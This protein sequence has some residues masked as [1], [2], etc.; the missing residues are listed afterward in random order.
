MLTDLTELTFS[1]AC[2]P[3]FE[4]EKTTDELKTCFTDLRVLGKID[5]KKILKWRIFMRDNVK[6]NIPKEDGL[7]LYM[8]YFLSSTGEPLMLYYQLSF[9]Q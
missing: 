8:K 3:Y 9:L 1:P 2:T 4:H 6:I 5:F 7:F